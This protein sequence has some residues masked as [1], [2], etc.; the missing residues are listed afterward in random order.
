MLNSINAPP[1]QIRLDSLILSSIGCGIQDIHPFLLRGRAAK[2]F[3]HGSLAGPSRVFSLALDRKVDQ[4]GYLVTED[5]GA[6]LSQVMQCGMLSTGGRLVEGD[7]EVCLQ[8]IRADWDNGTLN[9]VL[10]ASG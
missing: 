4:E 1:Q 10:P 5:F 3:V 9:L 8:A 6:S 7:F 2:L